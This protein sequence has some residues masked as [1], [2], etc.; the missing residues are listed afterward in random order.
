MALFRPLLRSRRRVVRRRSRAD[1]SPRRVRR[2]L[3][4]KDRES[5]PSKSSLVAL[6]ALAALGR[7]PSRVP[8]R[9]FETH[10]TQSVVENNLPVLVHRRNLTPLV[11]R[12]VPPRRPPEAPRILKQ[13]KNHRT[14]TR[15]TRPRPSVRFTSSTS[16]TRLLAVPPDRYST[17]AQYLARIHGKVPA[18]M[19]KHDLKDPC[20]ERKRRRAAILSQGTTKAP[21]PYS[22]HGVPC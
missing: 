20:L 1:P 14:V 17:P 4:R 18:A 19:L 16:S 13:S 6:A 21:G 15:V 22:P 8:R 10:Q 3:R 2:V 5:S 11:H 7:S 9:A 12:A